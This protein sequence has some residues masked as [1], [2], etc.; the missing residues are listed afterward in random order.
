[1]ARLS[2]SNK[3]S[4]AA[5]TGGS[6]R[7]KGESP[8]GFFALLIFLA[9]LGALS[10]GYS[11]HERLDATTANNI[12]PLEPVSDS[13][14]SS[15][16]RAGDQWYEAYGLY[17]CDKFVAP[18]AKTDDPF[19][20]STKNDGI[21]YIHP[22][23]KQY[24]GK[25]ANLGVFAK[26]VGL[27]LTKDS[28]QVDG[29]ATVYKS[30]ETKCGDNVGELVVKEWADPTKANESIVVRSSPLDV[31]VKNNA[32][33][34]IAFIPKGKDADIPLPDSATNGALTGAAAKEAAETQAAAAAADTTTDPAATDGTTTAT[35]DPSAPSAAVLDPALTTTTTA[36]G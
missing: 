14:D 36:G 33:V 27:K 11:R 5:R 22:Y 31:R 7:R 19:G 20:I 2:G 28:L 15:K 30:G 6:S 29:D 24:A 18:I 21:L 34:T 17:I 16:D 10:V 4:R 35:T 13:T 1:M 32:A 25:N 3:V 8:Y 26:A 9:A 12:A 23:Q